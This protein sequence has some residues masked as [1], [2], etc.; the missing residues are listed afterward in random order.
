MG[1]KP[2]SEPRK[3]IRTAPPTPHGLTGVYLG[4]GRVLS[5]LW[6]G[7]TIVLPGD[8]LD[9]G[10][11][12][13][14]TG[15]WEPDNSGYIAHVLEPGDVFI[16]IGANVGYFTILAAELVKPNGFV[17]AFEPQKA[18]LP[19]IQESVIANGFQ[20]ICHVS[21]AAI[22][23][24]EADGLLGHC[25]LLSGSASMVPSFG[26]GSRAADIVTVR[27][28]DDILEEISAQYGRRLVP[29]IIKM[30]IEGYEYHAW[31]GMKR[32]VAAAERIALIIEFA[33]RRYLN[34]GQDAFAFLD[35]LEAAG[36]TLFGLRDTD[37]VTRKV[38]F[39]RETVQ[40]MIEADAWIDLIAEK[41]DPMRR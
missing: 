13:M 4:R 23:A 32:T 31:Q 36:L 1:A 21:D 24:T 40:A 34:M 35:E 29:T 6:T 15:A 11:S 16:D 10:P 9:V 26:D 39:K 33:P 8:T 20:R 5:R 28:L 41:G 12:I 7:N 19:F 37:Q 3:V 17:V 38:P 18:L 14:T 25:D 2:P 27:P 22:G 30:D